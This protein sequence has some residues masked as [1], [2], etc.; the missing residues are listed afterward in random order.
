VL[1]PA[2]AS[3][4]L[5]EY[6]AIVELVTK[7]FAVECAYSQDS[8]SKIECK[9]LCSAPSGEREVCM[10]QPNFNWSTEYDSNVCKYILSITSAAP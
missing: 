5:K 1:K 10:N 6:D 3:P 7:L 9:Y 4:C 8:C 2:W